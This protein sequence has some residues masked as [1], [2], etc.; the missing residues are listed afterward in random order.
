MADKDKDGISDNV[1]IDGGTGTGKPVS[2]TPLADQQKIPADVQSIIDA[3]FASG[4]GGDSA[5]SGTDISTKK[6]KLTPNSALEIMTIAAED[7]GYAVKF[8]K[9]D[10]AQFMKEFDAEQA[11]QVEKV[12]T[13]TDQK[14]VAG[15]PSGTV[16]KV[17]STTA[18]TE[19]PS[20]FK[21]GEFTVDWIWKKINFKDEKSLGAKSLTA[22]AKVRGLV[23]KFQLIG[24][25]DADIRIAA[26]QIAMGKKTVAE[27]TVDLQKVAKKE[28]PQFADRF[29][30]DPELTTYDIASPVIK[31]LA[32]TWEMDEDD[33]S[34]D[35]PIVSSYMN[36]A[37][38]DGKGQPPSRAD[39]VA[40]A[41]KDSKYEGTVEANEN[42][43][44][45]AVGL[46]R[47]FGFGV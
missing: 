46:A 11:R 31:L 37:G 16:K 41:K 3:V 29:A 13:T 39:L 45:A 25:T 22:L 24:V 44:D 30:L 19:Y 47:A 20:F 15:A 12:I 17:A 4:G 6:T 40:K 23:D 21:P 38:P 34:I 42:A 7:A 9:A 27:Y 10:V 43:R 26:K 5:K 35:N 36:Y 18:Q 28:Y 1:D 32:K 14:T 8:T 33:I 2:K